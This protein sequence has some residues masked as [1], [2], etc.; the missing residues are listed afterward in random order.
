MEPATIRGCFNAK[1]PM[2][3]LSSSLMGGPGL[4]GG[5]GDGD[6][7]FR[8]LVGALFLFFFRTD[9]VLPQDQC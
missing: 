4:S 8:G 2:G 3:K 6:G 7:F 5:A 1:K 9:G